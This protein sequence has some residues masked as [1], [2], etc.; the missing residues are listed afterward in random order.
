MENRRKV[1]LRRLSLC[2]LILVLLIATAGVAILSNSKHTPNISPFQLL[3]T[4]DFWE[5]QS[6]NREHSIS[7]YCDAQ[8][9]N[10][11]YFASGA[12]FSSVGPAIAVIHQPESC[13]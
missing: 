12:G 1:V 13:K 10:L 9:G 5:T 11:I 2:L 3:G 4:M 8:R 7:V 6:K